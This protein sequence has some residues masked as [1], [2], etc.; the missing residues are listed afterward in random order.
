MED[1]DKTKNFFPFED[2]H[3]GLECINTEIMTNDKKKEIIK[4]LKNGEVYAYYN[5]KNDNIDDEFYK[6]LKENFSKYT[7]LS[8]LFLRTIENIN[9]DKIGETFINSFSNIQILDLSKN[10]F[11]ITNIDNL[12]I[13]LKENNTLAYLNLSDNGIEDINIL[14]EYL[15]DN[16]SLITLNLSNNEI[17]NIDSFEKVFYHNHTLK[18]LDLSDNYFINGDKASGIVN[19]CKGLS[20]NKGLCDLYMYNVGLNDITPLFNNLQD[21]NTLSVLN[22]MNNNISNVDCLDEFFKKNKSLSILNLK[23]NNISN[24]KNM[25]EGLKNNQILTNL[26]INDNPIKKDER[27]PEN[28]PLNIL[29]DVLEHNIIVSI[30]FVEKNN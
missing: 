18:E 11:H 8:E 14:C 24:I 26:Y 29:A 4:K 6:A 12:C 1:F 22:L 30:D 16:T 25:C 15:Y 3:A 19:F 21:N 17:Q 28:N 9:V 13:G 10:A 27:N 20:Q 23:G 7:N 2:D 5:F